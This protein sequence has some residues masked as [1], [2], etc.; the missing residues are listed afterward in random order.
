M[1]MTS[2]VSLRNG[3]NTEHNMVMAT[4]MPLDIGRMIHLSS[5]GLMPRRDRRSIIVEESDFIS[6]EKHG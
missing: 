6:H 2:I 3:S 5:R 1:P 4:L